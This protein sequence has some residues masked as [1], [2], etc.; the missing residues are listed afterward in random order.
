MESIK[1]KNFSKICLINI[2]FGK[3][4]NYFELWLN[5]C[6]YNSTID[7]IVFTDD[8]TKYD[9][10]ENV[11]IIYTSLKEIKEKI[12]KKFDFEIS[13][14][15]TYKL[16][17]YKPIY[18]Y[19]FQE[20]IHEYDFWGHC[21]LDVIFGNLRK[22][23]NEEILAQNDKIY[24]LGHFTLYKNIDRV[25]QNFRELINTNGVPLYKQVYTNNNS[26]YFDEWTGIINL[27]DGKKYKM[28]SNPFVIANIS[29]KY[30]NFIRNIKK[31][32]G[33]Y[34]FHWRENNNTSQLIGIYLNNKKVLEEEFMYIH[35]E[36]RKMKLNINNK[37]NDFYIVPNKFINI[38]NTN[39]MKKYFNRLTIIRKE[40]IQ[41]RIKRFFQ[42]IF[43]KG[44]KTI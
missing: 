37:N 33:K 36:K 8:K 20:Y 9:C 6:K 29:C 11:R 3:L 23:L 44:K 35:L 27:Y 17:D 39:N 40:Y 19:V 15:Y 28:Y 41:L 42:K 22:F 7:F 14:E 18:G 24:E 16:C 12:Q 13:L 30:N 43:K 26:F 21:D 25:N 32:N 31:E 2:Y 4:P 1:E 10:P 5:S 34:I 38:N